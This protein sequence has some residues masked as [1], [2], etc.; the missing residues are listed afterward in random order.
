MFVEVNKPGML[1]GSN[2]DVQYLAVV[3]RFGDTTEASAQLI[4]LVHSGVIARLVDY[5]DFQLI[6]Q[7]INSGI[8]ISTE[9]R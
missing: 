4:A 2:G 6:G 7:L 3:Q 9:A 5:S 1:K 8:I